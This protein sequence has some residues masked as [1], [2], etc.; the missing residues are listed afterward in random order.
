VAFLCSKCHQTASCGT[1]RLF[2]APK[3]RLWHNPAQNGIKTVLV[4]FWSLKWHKN[5]FSGTKRPFMAQSRSK[6]HKNAFS[7]T[8]IVKMPSVNYFTS[9]YYSEGFE[10][11]GFTGTSAFAP[12][13]PGG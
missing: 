3:G 12:K 2:L 10:I 8:K 1:K 13:L 6:W 9:I 7:A 5:A 11:T 4:P